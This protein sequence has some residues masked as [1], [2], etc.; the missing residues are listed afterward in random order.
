MGND[1]ESVGA[2]A[3][4]GSRHLASLTRLDLEVRPFGVVSLLEI[5]RRLE[6]RR[7]NTPG[8]GRP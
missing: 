3:L 2:E 5:Q 8:R 1:I 7:H 6:A 4:A